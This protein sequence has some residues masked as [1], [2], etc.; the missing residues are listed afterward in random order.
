MN[1]LNGHPYSEQTLEIEHRELQSPNTRQFIDD[2]AFD[3]SVGASST[4]LPVTKSVVKG[5]C[6]CDSVD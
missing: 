4:A 2:K 3:E 6:S 5:L 1:I